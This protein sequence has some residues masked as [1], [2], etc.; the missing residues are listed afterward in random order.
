[1]SGHAVFV[2][3]L[4]QR[5]AMNSRID[6]AKRCCAPLCERPA[7]AWALTAWMRNVIV[8]L[9]SLCGHEAC[10]LWLTI[11]ARR[12]HWHAL[13]AKSIEAVVEDV[14]L[15]TAL[16]DAKALLDNENPSDAGAYVEAMRMVNEFQVV[17]WGRC[18]N[19]CGVA[20]SS[21]Q[22]LLKMQSLC[23]HAPRAAAR[24][25]ATGTPHKSARTVA[26]RFRQR[27]G[28]HIGKVKPHIQITTEEMQRKVRRDCL[29][30][31]TICAPLWA[32]GK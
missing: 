10:G 30:C 27:W 21:R 32:V 23:C 22:L 8:I 17:E 16:E 29:T 31:V 20:P 26:W 11:E 12:R 1:M 4:R 25:T 15:A 7:M 28:L 2:D 24:L 18:Q 3:L 9:F 19:E 13:D 14:F 5:G 6:A